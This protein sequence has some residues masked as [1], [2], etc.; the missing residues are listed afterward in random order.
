M[1]AGL[2][3]TA[4]SASVATPSLEAGLLRQIVLDLPDRAFNVVRHL[5]QSSSKA[6]DAPLAMVRPPTCPFR[7]GPRLR[8]QSALA[9]E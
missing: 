5:E 2:G 6:A 9:I 1:E 8:A 7:I 3:A 4:M